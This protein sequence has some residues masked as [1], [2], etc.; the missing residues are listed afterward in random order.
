[1]DYYFLFIYSCYSGVGCIN[2][3]MARFPTS[4]W[5]PKNKTFFINMT[6]LI[7]ITIIVIIIL[8]VNNVQ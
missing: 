3:P 6:F 1:M 2:C 4:Q 5:I 7:I 8:I